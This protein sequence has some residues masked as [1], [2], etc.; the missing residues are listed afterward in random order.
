M[1]G[2][3]I[4]HSPGDCSNEIENIFMI[5]SKGI[6]AEKDKCHTLKICFGLVLRKRRFYRK[7]ELSYLGDVSVKQAMWTHTF[8]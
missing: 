6:T 2:K 3:R 4:H 8:R 7:N 5:I 1:E